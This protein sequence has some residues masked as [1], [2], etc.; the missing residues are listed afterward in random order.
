[1]RYVEQMTRIALPSNQMTS[2]VD[3]LCMLLEGNKLSNGKEILIN[4]NKT[5]SLLFIIH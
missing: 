5:P 3:L 1:V 4:E 2:Q